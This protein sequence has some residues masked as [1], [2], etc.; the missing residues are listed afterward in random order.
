MKELNQ[1]NGI[2][3]NEGKLILDSHK[4]AYHFDRLKAWEEGEKIAPISVD[5]A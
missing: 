5:M 3:T 1:N 2:N 4:L